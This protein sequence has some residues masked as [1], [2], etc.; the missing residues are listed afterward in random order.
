M[1]NIFLLTGVA[2]LASYL[3]RK[4]RYARLEQYAHIPQLPNHLLFGHLKVFGEF[5]NRG[6]HDRHPGMITGDT[7]CDAP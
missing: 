6:I 3:Y 7:T 4:L 2:L 5:M 1:F